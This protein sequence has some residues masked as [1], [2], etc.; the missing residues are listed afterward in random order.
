LTKQVTIKK[1]PELVQLPSVPTILKISEI[2]SNVYVM[3]V[4]RPFNLNHL[5]KRGVK[6]CFLVAGTSKSARTV[7]GKEI[8]ILRE[9]NR[10]VTEI[11]RE[12]YPL[13]GKHVHIY[14][15]LKI[16]YGRK[17]KDG[18]AYHYCHDTQKLLNQ[19]DACGFS[20]IPLLGFMVPIQN[21]PIW[22]NFS[23]IKGIDGFTAAQFGRKLYSEMELEDLEELLRSNKILND[24]KVFICQTAVA[25]GKWMTCRVNPTEE[26]A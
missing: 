7:L 16:V 5:V 4:N 21:P 19:L 24:L 23:Q 14:F 3:K 18:M 8:E 13:L 25:T 22:I 20:A 2:P 12:N 26:E 9:A 10:K 6:T 11:I 1:R 15:G 17:S